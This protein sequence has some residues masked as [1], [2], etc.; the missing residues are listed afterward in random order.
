MQDDLAA[1]QADVAS[2]TEIAAKNPDDTLIAA[3][4]DDAKAQETLAQDKLADAQK[5]ADAVADAPT[6]AAVTD[7]TDA[8][9]Q[10]AA[11][12]ADAL[13]QADRDVS[14]GQTKS[15]AN[16]DAA[17]TAADVALADNI[18]QIK[19]NIS[20]IQDD[21]ATLT[22]LQDKNPGNTVIA[23]LL[24]DAQTQLAESQ[25]SLADVT[26]LAN[27]VEDQPTLADVQKIVD[28][29]QTQ[30]DYSDGDETQAQTDVD[31]AQAE[32]NAKLNDAKQ[33]ATTAANQALQDIQQSIAG[34]QEDIRQLEQ[35]VTDNPGD[36]TIANALADA[37]AQLD[38]AQATQT[39]AQQQAAKIAAATTLADVTAVTYQIA[40]DE[41][42]AGVDK[43]DADAALATGQQ[44]SAENLAAA[45]DAAKQDL[46]DNIDAIQNNVAEIQKIV[47]TITDIANKNPNDADIRA[48]LTNAQNQLDKANDALTDAKQQ[49]ATV[50]DAKTLAQ[51]AEKT[52]AG[53]ADEK[54]SDQ[55]VADAQTELKQAGAKSAD[56]LA[57]AVADAMKQADASLAAIQADIEQIKDDISQIRAI[58][59]KN[60]DNQ[61]I[62]DLLADA[63]MQ[64]TEAQSRYQAA[65]AAKTELQDKNQTTTLA[66]VTEKL[67]T[68]SDKTTAADVD[69]KQA[70]QDLANAKVA[71]ADDLAD[72]KQ[73]ATDAINQQLDRI[74]EQIKQIAQDIADLNDLAKQH[75][76]SQAVKDAL[77]DAKQQLGDAQDAKQTAQDQLQQIGQAT[78]PDTVNNLNDAAQAAGGAVTDAV[79]AANQ[80][81]ADAK[82]AVA[83]EMATAKDA[84]KDAVQ[85]QINQ[86]TDN[87]KQIQDI[88]DQLQNLVNQHPGNQ[89]LAD[90][91]ASAQTQLKAA[92]QAL[93]NARDQ[94]AAIDAATTPADI[95]KA[96]NQIKVD[97]VVGQQ[98]L[99]TAQR[100]LADA[101]TIVAGLSTTATVVQAVSAG[102]TVPASAMLAYTV[103]QTVAV[104]G[105]VV[106]VTTTGAPE[107]RWAGMP[108][109]SI[110]QATP[111]VG[112]TIGERTL[113]GAAAYRALDNKGARIQDRR[114]ALSDINQTQQQDSHAS[115]LR[116]GWRMPYYL[117]GRFMNDWHLNAANV[118][119]LLFFGTF[120]GW[121]F[122]PAKKKEN[123]EE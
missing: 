39:D 79:K 123:E 108:V 29:A 17:K 56:N 114:V 57:D 84:A 119:T 96:V 10:D 107:Y 88:V 4:L 75:P 121:F 59:A 50:D 110:D 111:A 54:R 103:P 82:A 62:A 42:S 19:Q 49:L 20:D 24:A 58:A 21:I 87:V 120:L 112:Q 18:A 33:A 38:T 77:A 1:I 102:Q 26:N 109:T 95:A 36:T 105:P 72:A 92:Q 15:D 34:I 40:H 66:D 7:L 100:L 80:D 117:S 69:R 6:M 91:L 106:T 46:Q 43:E 86:L 47:E 101:Q 89:A 8:V 115:L 37:Q 9:T 85:Q 63:N 113:A 94:L 11:A 30:T 83:N 93:D 52:A 28:A 68:I 5:Q 61:K 65:Q 16:L 25:Q 76:D 98:A 55:A 3:L 81:L 53:D 97:Q 22:D 78:T 70:D 35:L 13:T 73:Q 116:H 44:K 12:T 118:A 67:Q 32:S 122:L 2:L 23:N 41:A 27:Q 45:K 64:L 48:A 99:Q 31:K 51:V 71:A 104:P 14:D 74:D 90:K 60:P